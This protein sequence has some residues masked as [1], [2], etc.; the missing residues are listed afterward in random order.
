MYQLLVKEHLSL[1]EDNIEAKLPDPKDVKHK[2]Y[3]F[4]KIKAGEYMC[5]SD[6]NL[7]ARLAFKQQEFKYREREIFEILDCLLVQDKRS[8]VVHGLRGIGK[9]SLAKAV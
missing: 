1:L 9:S 4:Q 5:K 2:C 6:H 8:V 7:G 3:R